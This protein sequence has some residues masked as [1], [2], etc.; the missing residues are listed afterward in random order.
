MIE[1]VFSPQADT[2]TCDVSTVSKPDLLRASRWHIRDVA[3]AMSFFVQRMILAACEHDS[4]KIEWIDLFFSD[5]KT[6]FAE[7]DWLQRH[8][9]ITRHHLNVQNGIPEDVNLVD[10]LEYV[11][12][13]VMSAAARTGRIDVADIGIDPKVLQDA[14][15][16][17]VRMLAENVSVANPDDLSEEF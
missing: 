12:D 7:T 2:R 17:T 16:N 14:F 13:R 1:V 4:D 5:F 8:Y 15:G 6:G 11:A 9:Q 3:E 10:V